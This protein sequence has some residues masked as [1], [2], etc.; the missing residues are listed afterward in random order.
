[1]R[2]KNSKDIVTAVS[3]LIGFILSILLIKILF[4]HNGDDK[5]KYGLDVD[6]EEYFPKIYGHPIHIDS[7]SNYP[8]LKKNVLQS[9]NDREL[10]LWLG[11]SQLYTINQYKVGD[12]NSVE[13]L[14][15]QIDTSRY[16]VIAYSLPNANLQEHYA[17][18]KFLNSELPVKHLILPV[19]F[20]DTRETGIRPDLISEQI[21]KSVSGS[22][23]STLLG[24]AL[25]NAFSIQNFDD[26]EDMDMKALNSTTQ[27]NVERW[28]NEK[29]AS[30]SEIWASRPLIRIS[31][32]YEYIF[33][34][35]NS[36]LGIDPNTKRKKIP[37]RY[38]LNLEAFR[39]MVNI[40]N[41]QGIKMY[42]YL[43]PIRGDVEQPY[44][45][46]E[47]NEFKSDISKICKDA[48]VE[49]Y[50]AE[51]IIPARYWGT[52]AATTLGNKSREIDFM[53]F[54]A[55]GHKIL[56]DSLRKHFK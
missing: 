37:A 43:A 29:L 53:H 30:V 45:I 2:K 44:Y 27:E 56:A 3:I 19:F 54:Q 48:G 50:N 51:G 38:A 8:L 49:Y 31:F 10:I 17:L 20:D 22:M 7:I 28:L 36:I 35:R 40:V 33:S 47:Y 13:Y 18:L 1:M 24:K 9:L 41:S 21:R 42:V 6:S 55:G 52:K 16:L 32:I 26:P 39:R 15:K 23:D 25:S 5:G 4:L 12:L 34:F 11:N 14:Y 46:N